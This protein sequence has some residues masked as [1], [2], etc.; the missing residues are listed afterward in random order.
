MLF[1][2][3]KPYTIGINDVV[4]VMLF[5]QTHTTSN[6]SVMLAPIPNSAA[7]SLGTPGYAV[8]SEG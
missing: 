6:I 3:P 1:A 4:S 2:D 7:D 8:D 5:D